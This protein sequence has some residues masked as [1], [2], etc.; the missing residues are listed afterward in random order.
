[1]V[2]TVRCN[3]LFLLEGLNEPYE[4]LSSS[5]FHGKTEVVDMGSMATWGGDEVDWTRF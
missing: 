1:M 3:N 4:I 2:S 5:I